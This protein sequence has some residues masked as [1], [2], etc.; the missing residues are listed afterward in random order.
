VEPSRIT[1][2]V[3]EGESTVWSNQRGVRQGAQNSVPSPKIRRET[4]RGYLSAAVRCHLEFFLETHVMASEVLL[5][6]GSSYQK[7][8]VSRRVWLQ[9]ASQISPTLLIRQSY[10]PACTKAP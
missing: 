7:F 2:P 3:Y 8:L 9:G 5:H 1:T 10:G 6:A 4:T